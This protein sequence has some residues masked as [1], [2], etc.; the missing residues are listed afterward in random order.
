VEKFMQN[1]LRTRISRIWF[2]VLVL[3]F[4]FGF[5]YKSG[6]YEDIYY[7]QLIVKD[8]AIKEINSNKCSDLNENILSK[9]SINIDLE[10]Y[11]QLSQKRPECKNLIDL[12]SSKE[13]GPIPI[14]EY[15]VEKEFQKKYQSFIVKNNAR[16]GLEFLIIAFI[17]IIIL[18]I[19]K[20]IFQWIT[21]GDKQ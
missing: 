4:I 7:E 10:S 11:Y 15:S 1:L 16:T 20:N 18:K 19:S 5:F 12:I 17:F 6:T 21:S 8:A 13:S 14:T 3:S 2:A 9:A